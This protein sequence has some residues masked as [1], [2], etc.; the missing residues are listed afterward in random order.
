MERAAPSE[1]GGFLSRKEILECSLVNADLARAVFK[2][3]AD[4]EAWA[5]LIGKVRSGDI[6]GEHVGTMAAAAAPAAGAAPAVP[7]PVAVPDLPTK[8]PTCGAQLPELMRG[9][10][11]L[12]CEFCGAVVR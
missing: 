5:A 11:S 8:C 1:R 4:S 9:Q 7:P 3:D 12:T 6:A 10:I 2:L